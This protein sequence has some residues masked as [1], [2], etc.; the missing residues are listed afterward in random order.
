MLGLSVCTSIKNVSK[1]KPAPTA[2]HSAQTARNNRGLLH[3]GAAFTFC[4]NQLGR[5]QFGRFI[6]IF[7]KVALKRWT[8][9]YLFRTGTTNPR[10]QHAG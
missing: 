8:E 1:P 10:I 4:G 9:G 7:R 2:H 3:G 5:L 6:P